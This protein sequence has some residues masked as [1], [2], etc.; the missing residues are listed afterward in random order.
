MGPR[1]TERIAKRTVCALQWLNPS[2][3]GSPQYIF[4]QASAALTGWEK[5]EPTKSRPPLPYVVL[6]AIAMKLILGRQYFHAL[7]LVTMFESYLRVSEALALVG[8]CVVPAPPASSQI[9]L[10][11]AILARPSVFVEQTKTG[12]QDVS[13]LLDLDRQQPLARLLCM[14]SAA[15]TAK[16]RLWDFDYAELHKVL[17]SVVHELGLEP[18]HIT[19][20]TL[21]QGGP[22]HDRVVGA[23]T[24]VEV[25]QRGQWKQMASCTRYDKHAL[26]SKQLERIPKERRPT[27]YSLASRFD[28]DFETSFDGL[29]VRRTMAV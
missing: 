1:G 5:Q 17:K 24:L 3:K 2:L 19:L 29:F 8:L 10:R 15:V 25:Q 9:S 12:L 6:K 4:P 26:L 22:S 16:Q 23:R 7:I 21:R 27:I 14:L 11:T 18:L 28:T 20:H 13:I